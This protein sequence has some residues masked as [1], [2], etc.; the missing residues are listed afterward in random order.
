M[1]TLHNYFRSHH[2]FRHSYCHLYVDD[3]NIM[4][5]S[6]SINT[7]L[8]LIPILYDLTSHTLH[9]SGFIIEHEK[10]EGMH[11]ISSYHNDCNKINTL[12]TLPGLPSPITPSTQL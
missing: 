7:N 3:G 1:Y 4:A 6:P 12:I 10:T 9:Q 8:Q 11:F 2:E 5:T